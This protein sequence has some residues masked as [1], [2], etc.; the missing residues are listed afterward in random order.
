[1]TF[2][3]SAFP[4]QSLQ[5]GLP[6]Q[7]TS[8][9]NPDSISKADRDRFISG[10]SPSH[11]KLLL[12][13]LRTE[14]PLTKRLGLTNL[15][16]VAAAHCFWE[17]L[18]YPA[19]NCCSRWPEELIWVHIY[20]SRYLDSCKAALPSLL[21]AFLNSRVHFSCIS[22]LTVILNGTAVYE[23]DH[24]KRWIHS[25][26]PLTSG[27]CNSVSFNMNLLTVRSCSL[28]SPGQSHL[29]YTKLNHSA[30]QT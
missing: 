14:N 18:L 4:A 20:S 19:G 17:I 9:L 24:L 7:R 13:H 22:T 3:V 25:S 10:C 2:W 21:H 15:V 30:L 5:A 12:V 11:Q 29:R 26:F 6:S 27:T 28:P 23:I 16:K 1:M 8:I